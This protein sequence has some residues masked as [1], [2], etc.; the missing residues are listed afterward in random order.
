MTGGPTQAPQQRLYYPEPALQPRSPTLRSVF[1]IQMKV[2]TRGLWADLSTMKP[3][4]PFSPLREKHHW[5]APWSQA[6]PP[7]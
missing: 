4:G 7:T 1:R 5:G 6:R 2:Q 3:P